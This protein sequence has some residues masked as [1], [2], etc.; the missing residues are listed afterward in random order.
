M[1]KTLPILDFRAQIMEA[2]NNNPAT[3]IT[4]ETGAGKSTQV[5]QFLLDAGYNVVVTQP[6]IMAARTVA[7]RVAEELGEELGH[8]VGYR[9]A[10]E[11]NFSEFTRCLFCTDGLTLVHELVGVGV[12]GKT[13]LVLDEVHEWNE[14]MEVLVAWAKSQID[15]GADFKVVLMSATME[16]EKLGAFFNNAPVITVPGRLFPV[17]VK[18]AGMSI[19]N[20]VVAL[21]AQNRNVL[22]FQPG[23]QE[24]ADTCEALAKLQLGAEILPLHG[25]LTP[26]EQ[27][28]CFRHYGR[29]KVVVATNVAQTSITIDDIDGVV[30]SGLQREI[31]LVDGVEGLYL[32]PISLADSEQ[33][34]GRA[35]R[36]KPG[37]YIDHCATMDRPAFPVPAILRTR[38][39][40]T[41]LRLTIAGFDMEELEFFHQPNK[42]DIHDA[43]QT[44]V[45]LGCMTHDGKVTP[46][47]KLVN[48]LPVSVQFARML[49]EADRLDVVDDV[50]TV[51]AIMEIGGIT[52]APPSRNCPNRPD[53][54]Y[55]VPNE[56]ESDVMG[57]LQVWELA[58]SMTKDEMYNK[59]ISLRSYFRAKEIRK[60][61]ERSIRSHFKLGSSGHRE[62]I[63]KAVCAGMVDHLYKN[64]YGLCRNGDGI[65]REI[66]S[67]SVIRG[68]AEWV[69]GKPFDLEI[70]T[71][72]GTRV[73]KLIELVSK[74][75]PEW[76]IEIA[77]QLVEQ[78]TGLS[79]Y[80]DEARDVVVSTT[81]T[82]FNGHVVS[83]ELVADGTYPKAA[84][85]FANWFTDRVTA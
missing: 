83:T 35:G 32:V 3:V 84:E 38:L 34:K 20:D 59:G 45:G 74:V 30:D 50:L 28:R 7:G 61:L 5:P 63:L 81:E 75:H 48:R 51:A 79:P 72:Y 14:N 78:N 18:T 44:L 17:E 1:I 70:K 66:G 13:V 54:R 46:I 16:A 85:I 4:A 77:P 60:N 68:G 57:Q 10:N 19:A 6:R 24:I 25:Q 33:R 53:W 15:A 26:E 82:S 8:T 80:Y 22:V 12:G 76:L 29:P 27:A 71:R 49:V 65:D 55:M 56:H 39:D 43:H 2:I 11:Q 62:N 31:Q 52:V 40:K 67:A 42:A 36:T 37:T 9:T 58:E 23:K 73:L 69:V 21:V 64:S 47:G 41:Y